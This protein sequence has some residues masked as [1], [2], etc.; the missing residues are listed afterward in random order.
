MDEALIE[1]HRLSNNG[2][3]TTFE[4]DHDGEHV[5]SIVR[6]KD[7]RR[8]VGCHIDAEA[9]FHDAFMEYLKDDPPKH[10]GCWGPDA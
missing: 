2:F 1:L 8:Y 4:V 3:V 7:D 9:A 10:F 5:V 6:K